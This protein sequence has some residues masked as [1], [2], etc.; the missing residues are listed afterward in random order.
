MCF[1]LV[2]FN[3]NNLQNPQKEKMMEEFFDLI[4]SIY[5]I[6]RGVK[7]FIGTPFI[8]TYIFFDKKRE[9][10]KKIRE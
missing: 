3:T 8:L 5:A 10:K 4:A 2:Y 1:S 7:A 9:K 6:Q